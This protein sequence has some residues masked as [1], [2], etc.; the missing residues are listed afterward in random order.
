MQFLGIGVFIWLTATIAFRLI[1]QFLLDPTNL[2]LSIGLFLATALVMFVVMTAVYLWR[3]VKLLDRP[4][5][6]MLVA[7]PGMLLDVGSVLSFPTVFPNID[8]NANIL[9]AGLMLWGYASILITGFLPE[10]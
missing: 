1:G 5:A 10:Q 4:K 6:A 8:P 2:V 3:Q 7:L 9:F